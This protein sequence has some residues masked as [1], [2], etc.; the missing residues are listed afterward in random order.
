MSPMMHG[1]SG[2]TIFERIV[3]KD[4]IRKATSVDLLIQ[5]ADTATN[6]HLLAIKE[7]VWQALPYSIC[8]LLM[9]WE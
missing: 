4:D 1:K 5:V 7:K 2:K 9:W 6:M 3:Q 8:G